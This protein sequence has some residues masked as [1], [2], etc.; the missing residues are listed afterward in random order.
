[1]QDEL[2]IIGY[3]GAGWEFGS[4][5]LGARVLKLWATDSLA[6]WLGNAFFGLVARFSGS[7]HVFGL[8]ARFRVRGRLRR[9]A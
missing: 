2:L 5:E 1:M 6:V 8:V 4:Q 3:W 9:C 7:W